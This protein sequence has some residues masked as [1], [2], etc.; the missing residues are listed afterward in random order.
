M[1]KRIFLFGLSLAALW[2]VSAQADD[3]ERV[4]D[5]AQT[6]EQTQLTTG[7]ELMTPEER[8]Q[9]RMKMRNA[10]SREER[11]QMREEHHEEMKERAHEQGKAIPDQ[12][13]A[14]GM[15]KGMRGGGNR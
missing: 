3:K 11:E 2:A 5:K 8:Q 9:Q 6:R 13:P 1:D 12:P 7:R 14:G 15:G 10:K 4:R